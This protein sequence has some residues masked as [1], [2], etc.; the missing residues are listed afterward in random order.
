MAWGDDWH[1]EESEKAMAFPCDSVLSDKAE[2]WYRAVSVDAP[3]DLVFR[4]LCQLRV[5][6]YSYDWIDN[7]GRPSPR[8][9]TEGI[10]RLAVGQSVM[11]LF[12]LVSFEWGRHLTVRLKDTSVFPPIAMTYM[13]LPDGWGGTRLLV[14]VLVEYSGWSDVLLRPWFARADLFMMKKQLLTLKG[15]SERQPALLGEPQSITS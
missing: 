3:P 2:A 13:A 6:P 7:W 5:A 4:W 15:L 8:T 1:F 14:K 12:E 10:D 11:T 9:L